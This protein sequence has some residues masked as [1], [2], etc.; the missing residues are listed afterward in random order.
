MKTNKVLLASA[1]VAVMGM[2]MASQPAM[3]F[4][5]VNW[6]WNKLIEETVIKD[7]NVTIDVSPTGMTEIEKMQILIGD[8]TASSSVTNVS[9]NPPG[10]IVDG[11]LQVEDFFHI[12][13]ATDDSTDPS[14]IDPAP[15]VFGSDLVLQAELLG[16][17]YDEGT[18][19][20]EMDFG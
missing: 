6:E 16:G 10:E 3:A 18:D 1:A 7:V 19:V 17:T 11:V 8:V 14:T 2:A 9:N 13:S 20:R 4:D 15:G 12:T 5:T